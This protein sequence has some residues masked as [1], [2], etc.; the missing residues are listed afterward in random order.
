MQLIDF[1]YIAFCII[2]V[3]GAFFVARWQGK[4]ELERGKQGSATKDR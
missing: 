1:L 2:V 3:I 4:R